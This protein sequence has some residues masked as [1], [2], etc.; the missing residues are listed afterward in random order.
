MK[1]ELEEVIIIMKI[2]IAPMSI[3]SED[4]LG[5]LECKACQAAIT[6]GDLPLA[7]SRGQRTDESWCKQ[8]R[9]RRKG[10]LKEKSFVQE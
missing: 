8:T 3:L 2:I 5:D 10:L 7:R 6:D 4:E 1:I 9:L